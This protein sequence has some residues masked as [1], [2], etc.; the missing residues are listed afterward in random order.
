MSNFNFWAD[1]RAFWAVQWIWWVGNVGNVATATWQCGINN[2]VMWTWQ[3]SKLFLATYWSGCAL[4]NL[5]KWTWQNLQLSLAILLIKLW[6]QTWLVSYYIRN[7]LFLSIRQSVVCNGKP[8]E[9]WGLSFSRHGNE[10]YILL[11]KNMTH[12]AFCCAWSWECWVGYEKQEQTITM[13]LI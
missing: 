7:P 8:K 2:L 13:G 4:G 10:G 12:R 9:Q 11:G 3:L 1:W 6:L 5:A